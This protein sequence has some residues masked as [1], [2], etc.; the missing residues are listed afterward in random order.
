MKKIL[1]IAVLASIVSMPALALK[2][3]RDQAIEI[4]AD[5]FNGDEVK[6]TATYDGHVNVSQG[7]INFTGDKL[8]LSVTP[9]GYRRIVL[10]GNPARFKQQSDPKNK[11]VDEW[12]HAQAKQLIYDEESDKITL[13]GGAQLSRSENGLRKD[14]TSGNSIIYDMRN[15]RSEVLGGLV[16]GERQRVTTIIAPRKRPSDNKSQADNNKGINLAPTTTITQ[17]STAKE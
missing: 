10:N 11:G 2:S 16:N 7:S 14:L 13:K 3:D 9:R 4:H 15:A 1:A 6:Q 12:V 8:T 5:Q 17:P